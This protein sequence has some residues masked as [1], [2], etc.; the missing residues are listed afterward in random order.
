MSMQTKKPGV[1]VVRAVMSYFASRRSRSTEI[2]RNIYAD[3]GRTQPLS[4]AAGPE[5]VRQKGR[6]CAPPFLAGTRQDVP[7]AP[8]KGL[9][10]FVV[11]DLI[12]RMRGN[13]TGWQLV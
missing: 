8:V 7:H 10:L 3:C 2:R 12:R 5:S 4:C 9:H 11:K 1:F 13:R 6:L